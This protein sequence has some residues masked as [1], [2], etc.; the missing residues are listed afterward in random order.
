MRAT[1]PAWAAGDGSEA[2]HW[3][4]ARHAVQA[5]RF[6]DDEWVRD[7]LSAAPKWVVAVIAG[8]GFGTGMGIFIRSDGSGWTETVVSGLILGVAFGIPM[9]F[10]FD[11]EQRE[12]RAVEGELPTD[13]LQAAH[14]AAASGPVPEDPEVRAAALRITTHQLQR[15]G[16]IPMPVRI[17]FPLLM[18]TASVIGSVSGSPWN[19][20]FAVAPVFILINHLYVPRRTRR[21]IELLAESYADDGGRRCTNEGR[22]QEDARGRSGLR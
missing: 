17:G 2:G 16:Q 15:D 7:Y 1:R 21:R 10:W 9:A 13:K 22:T 20:L 11:K 6:G 19:L 3:S 4:G 14:R 18:L 12:M 5:R 8:T